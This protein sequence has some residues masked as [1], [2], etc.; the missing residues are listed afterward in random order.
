MLVA[1]QEAVE[2]GFHVSEEEIR[3]RTR[4]MFGEPSLRAAM[5]E[6]LAGYERS[7]IDLFQTET[8]TRTD[9]LVAVSVWNR[10]ITD[11]S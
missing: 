10:S 2:T 5:R 1:L 8:A 9:A 4:F 3:S 6:A 11:R 7:V